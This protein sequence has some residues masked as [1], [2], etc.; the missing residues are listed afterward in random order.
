MKPG[1]RE[2][3]YKIIIA[4]TRDGKGWSIIGGETTIKTKIKTRA[5]VLFAKDFLNGK[6]DL[7]IAEIG[8]RRGYNAENMFNELKPRLMVLVDFWDGSIKDTHSINFAETWHR[9]HGRRNIIFVKAISSDAANLID[10]RISFDFVY[11]DAS[12][13]KKNVLQDINSWLPKVKVGGILAG[14]DYTNA[15]V[16]GVKEVVHEVFGDRV[17]VGNNRDDVNG[18]WWIVKEA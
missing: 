15:D 7:N 4:T 3:I 14:H 18:D 2:H 13:D 16:P 5:S 10:Q 8:V 9:L 1:K 12:H 17:K 11:L 6:N